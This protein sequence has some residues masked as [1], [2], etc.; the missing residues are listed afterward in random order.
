MKVQSL[1]D[2]LGYIELSDTDSFMSWS[3][4]SVH[5][6]EKLEKEI[7]ERDFDATFWSPSTLQESRSYTA[8]GQTS[9]EKRET[10]SHSDD[11]KIHL[12][13]PSGLDSPIPSATRR[14]RAISADVLT[15]PEPI[16]ADLSDLSLEIP[17]TGITVM[18]GDKTRTKRLPFFTT[19][20][21]KSP[22][23]RAPDF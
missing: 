10:P 23:P 21:T 22:S 3:S 16:E 14:T 5:E 7:I 17:I 2:Q 6:H 13:T 20:S 1:A 4:T 11:L 18:L 9:T 8:A 15:R 19:L 12:T